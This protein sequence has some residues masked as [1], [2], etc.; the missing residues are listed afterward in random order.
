MDG[1][2]NTYFI[3]ISQTQTDKGYRGHA[4]HVLAGS[5][6]EA[7]LVKHAGFFLQGKTLTPVHLGG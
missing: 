1:T 5:A 2:G 6:R 3:K 7:R 4:V